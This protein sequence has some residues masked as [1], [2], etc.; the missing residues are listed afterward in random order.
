MSNHR[1]YPV[2]HL[3]KVLSSAKKGD[4]LS[5]DE[6]RFLLHLTDKKDIHNLFRAARKLRQ[7]YFDNTV[8]LY[9]FVYFSTWCRNDCFFCFYRKSNCVAI[10]YRKPKNEIIQVARELSGSGVHLID[11]TMGEDPFYYQSS[12]LFLE[13]A[14]L[15]KDIK[16]ETGLPVM[17]SPG[18]VPKYTLEVLARAGADWYACYQETHNR[19]LFNRLRTQQNYDERLNRKMDA[20]QLGL[21]IEEGILTGIGDRPNDIVA[22]IQ[23]MRIIGAHQVRVMSF[24]PQ[25]GTPLQHLSRPPLERELIIISVLRLLFPDRLIPASLDVEGIKGLQSRLDAGANVVTSLVPPNKGLLG[26]SQNSLDIET[27]YRT[28]KGVFPILFE[29]GMRPGTRAEYDRWM[30]SFRKGGNILTDFTNI[31]TYQER[32]ARGQSDFVHS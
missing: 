8:F 18:V 6:I 22:S 12:Q 5:N 4:P 3:D 28:P 27:G 32:V 11:L 15:V 24:V 23:A 20:R 10:R 13:L 2:L 7:Q 17:I 31:R 16:K 1:R 29:S 14:E 25:R 9:G 26:V 21:L 19:V 30:S